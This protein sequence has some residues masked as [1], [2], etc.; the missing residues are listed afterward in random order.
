MPLLC[1]HESNIKIASNLLKNP[2]SSLRSPT[3]VKKIVIVVSRQLQQI[4]HE[5]QNLIRLLWLDVHLSVDHLHLDVTSSKEFHKFLDIIAGTVHGRLVDFAHQRV[6]VEVGTQPDGELQCNVLVDVAL[7]L[8]HDGVGREATVAEQFVERVV[9]SVE[10]W[11][12]SRHAY[13]SLLHSRT[14]RHNCRLSCS[15]SHF[16]QA[17]VADAVMPRQT[18]V[19]VLT[20]SHR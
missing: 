18:S 13:H 19:C 10:A 6:V 16:V 17:G 2:L 3:N 14:I 4:S 5:N 12:C 8:V 9:N 20:V 15:K 7:K 1:Q 11:R